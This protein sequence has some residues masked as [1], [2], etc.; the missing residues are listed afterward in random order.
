MPQLGLDPSG[1]LFDRITSVASLEDQIKEMIVSKELPIHVG[2][3][4]LHFKPHERLRLAE[5][6]NDF[7]Y[8]TNKIK[9]FLTMVRELALK[10]GTNP[11]DIFLD[12]KI[13]ATIDNPEIS[14]NQKGM[15]IREQLKKRKY[16]SLAMLEEKSSEFIKS[17]NL[18]PEI[19]LCLSDFFEEKKMKLEI[20]LKQ[21][22][23]LS[24]II[25]KLCS[26]EER[27]ELEN[28]FNLGIEQK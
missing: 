9:E 28:F 15:L 24:S 12:E 17:A 6:I 27:K 23:E 13:K 21:A 11:L 19:K 8:G 20:T 5:L 16:P 3:Y 7:G 22:D 10:D 14:G 4:F 26:L 25:R 18:S 1:Y 2:E